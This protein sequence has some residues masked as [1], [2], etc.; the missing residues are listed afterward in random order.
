MPAERPAGPGRPARPDTAL[1]PPLPPGGPAT[2]FALLGPVRAWHEERELDLGFPQQR[3]LLALLL[4]CA[5]RP[6][7]TGE[8]LDVLWAERPPASALN[9]VRRYIGN[10]RRLLEPGL[11]PR[12]P[13]RRLLRHAGGYLLAAQTDEVDL[14]RFREQTRQARRAAATGRPGTATRHF[15]RALEEWRGPVAMG[16]PAPARAHVHFTAV[17]RELLDAARPAADAALL[18]GHADRMLPVL[19][20]AVAQDPLDEPLHARLVLTLAACD[21][22][23]EALTT[24]DDLR[25]RLS[26]D[27]GVAPG[28]ELTAAHTR[29]LRQDVRRTGP[30]SGSGPVPGP[31]R[32]TPVTLLPRPAQLPPD[33]PVFTGRRAELDRLSELADSATGPGTLLIGGLAGVGKSALA[34]HWAHRAG[35]E[36]PDGRLYLALRGTDPGARPPLD[37]AEA[38]RGML[39]ALGVPARHLPE[40]LAALSG[41]YRTL[42][43]GRRVLVLLDDAAG[44]EQLRPLLPAATGCLALVTSRH[45]L[46]G[47]IAAGARPLRLEPPSPQDASELLALRIGAGRTAAEPHAVAEIVARCGRLPLALAV[48]AARAAARG[49]FPLAAVAAELRDARGTLDAFPA[50]REALHRS[51]RLLPER[52]AGLLPLLPRHPGPELTAAVVAVL[53]GLPIRHARLELGRLADAHLLTETAPGR[54][55]LHGLV[56]DFA[57]E[58]AERAEH[59]AS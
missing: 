55:V 57:A 29:V 10:L 17:Q 46:P 31:T 54:Y 47:L 26:T 39:A 5:G 34:V 30:G 14:L 50:V 9:I 36:F 58:L 27:L 2:R 48:V 8:M 25:R 7:P 3:A 40:G 45:A 51:H 59:A 24:Y 53:A 19:R 22:Q 16:I 43:A 4:A 11:P 56:R 37:P 32:P 13:G 1:S 33:L 44:T 42:L 41:L 21:L 23:A 28:P 15:T 52:G 18:A 49:D 35:A 38:L 20:R 6:V 12:A